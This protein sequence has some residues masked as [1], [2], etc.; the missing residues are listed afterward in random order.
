MATAYSR[1]GVI[2]L[3]ASLLQH[4]RNPE[5]GLQAQSRTLKE[6]FRP[7]DPTIVSSAQEFLKAV[8]DGAIHIEL[9]DHIDLTDTLPMENDENPTY[10]LD[11]APHIQSIRVRTS[12]MRTELKIAQNS[13]RSRNT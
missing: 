7:I 8:R 1:E 9:R 11:E 3:H 5:P 4:H 2:W 10:I 12:S 13:M 6:R